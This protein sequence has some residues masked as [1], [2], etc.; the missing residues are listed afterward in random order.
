MSLEKEFETHFVFNVV[1]ETHGRDEE[2]AEDNIR[3]FLN[4]EFVSNVS[5]SAFG[6]LLDYDVVDTKEIENGWFQLT[7][8]WSAFWLVTA[9]KELKARAIAGEMLDESLTPFY[10]SLENLSTKERRF[11]LVSLKDEKVTDVLEH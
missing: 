11:K 10:Q 4:D 6:T 3:K 2:G 7:L 1:V 8:R 5:V 9:D